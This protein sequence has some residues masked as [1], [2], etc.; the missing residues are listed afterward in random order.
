MTWEWSTVVDVFP[1]IFEA[2]WTTLGLTIVCF[3][4][5]L[6]VGGIWTFLK[7]I[8]FKPFNWLISFIIE[9]IRSTPPLVQLYFL[10]FAWPLIPYVGVTLEPFTVAVF[11]LGIHFSTYISEIYRSGIEGVPKGQIEA[12]TALN[13]T[14]FQKWTKVILPQAIPPVIPMLGN[15]LII[16]FKEI[17]LTIV[18]GVAG[19]LT[20]AEVYGV[21]NF[22]YLEPYTLVAFFFLAMSYPS[23]LF[24]QWLERKLNKRYE[25]DNKKSTKKG[26]T[27]S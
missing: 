7:R 4:V 19:M 21:N 6:I 1:H 26:V 2:M 8:K 11:G 25:S 17:P 12:A 16:M 10:F 14:T 18:V 3:T 24:V 15:Y 13:Y 9:F 27:T 22:E 20:A 23:A 5:A